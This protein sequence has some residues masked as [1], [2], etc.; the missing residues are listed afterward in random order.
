MSICYA[1]KLQQF[2]IMTD[3]F[4]EKKQATLTCDL[5]SKMFE[6]L[7][8]IFSDFGGSPCG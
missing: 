6:N 2:L 3:F 8:I 5:L 4:I 1:A 7:N